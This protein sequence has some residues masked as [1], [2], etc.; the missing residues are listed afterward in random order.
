MV[1]LLREIFIVKFYII[2]NFK[3]FFFDW[4]KEYLFWVIFS[5]DI[6]FSVKEGKLLKK[7]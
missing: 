7:L 6:N 4:K 1:D 3:V 2:V 5:G